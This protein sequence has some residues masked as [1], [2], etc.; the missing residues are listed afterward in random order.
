MHCEQPSFL[1][2]RLIADTDKNK[3]RLKSVLCL[4]V[5]CNRVNESEVD[6]ILHQYS[7]QYWTMHCYA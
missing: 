5:Q 4:L 1:D 6:V 2:P 7:D 3:A